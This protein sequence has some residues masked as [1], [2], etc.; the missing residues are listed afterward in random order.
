VQFAITQVKKG[1]KAIE[2]TTTIKE[3][4]KRMSYYTQWSTATLGMKACLVK[5]SQFNQKCGQA[6]T[7]T[8]DFHFSHSWH[9]HENLYRTM[10]RSRRTHVAGPNSKWWWKM[11]CGH[12]YRAM[13][14]F[15]KRVQDCTANTFW[16]L[17]TL[18]YYQVT[19]KFHNSFIW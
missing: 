8:T 13:L 7:N 19:G 3:M 18:I 14:S 5:R 16:N 17:K 6:Q 11:V 2:S 4:R 1:P 10:L 9:R 15:V 12:I